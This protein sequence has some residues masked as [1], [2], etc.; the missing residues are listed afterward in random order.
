MTALAAANVAAASSSSDTISA[1]AQNATNLV[2]CAGLPSSPAS[3]NSQAAVPTTSRNE[4]AA[5]PSHMA[6][7]GA[8]PA[9]HTIAQTISGTSST[10]PASIFQ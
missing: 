1:R 3:T 8:S 5:A 7:S 4:Q 9:D 2:A 6:A 10:L